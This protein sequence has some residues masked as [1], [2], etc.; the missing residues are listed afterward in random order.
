MLSLKQLFYR[1]E[2]IDMLYDSL[3]IIHILSA[4]LLLS[5]MAYCYHLWRYKQHRRNTG[6]ITLRIQTQ[7]MLVIIPL[8]FLQLATGFTMV[9]LQ[10]QGLSELW[11]K[12]SVIGFVVAIASW[13][14]FLYFLLRSQE[15]EVQ[16]HRS[17]S[18]LEIKYQFFRRIQSIMLCVCLLALMSMIFFMANKI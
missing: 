16:Y 3:K 11:V 7:T 2:N 13:I 10:H 4:T 15:V 9:S 8:A 5:D 14:S 1:F 12:G 6:I 17:I 18:I